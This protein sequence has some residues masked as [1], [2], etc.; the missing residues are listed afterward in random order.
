VALRGLLAAW[1]VSASGRLA[2]RRERNALA[3]PAI[4]LDIDLLQSDMYI[5]ITPVQ[6]HIENVGAA[7]MAEQCTSVPPPTATIEAWYHQYWFLIAGLMRW[8]CAA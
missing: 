6:T 2:A 7:Y 1:P 4:I 3:R 5:Q 8:R